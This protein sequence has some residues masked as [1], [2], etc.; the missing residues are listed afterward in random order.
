MAE[1]IIQQWGDDLVVF[2]PPGAGFP[3]NTWT[4]GP[5]Q[6]LRAA[7]EAAMA[8]EPPVLLAP[9]QKQAVMF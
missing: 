2:H 1:V 5:K 8:V 3:A 9:D 7:I 6:D 4:V